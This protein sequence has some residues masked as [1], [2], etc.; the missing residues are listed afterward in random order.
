MV[1]GFDNFKKWFKEYD[2]QFVI[3][4]GTA[5]DILMSVEGRDFRATKDIDII[6]THRPIRLFA[7]FFPAAAIPP[8]F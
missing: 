1:P 3:I 2:D 8:E 6:N 4:G 7:R 5:C